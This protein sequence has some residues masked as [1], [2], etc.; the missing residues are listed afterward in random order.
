MKG[1]TT[2]SGYRGYIPGTGY[3]LFTTESEYR[4]YYREH[5]D[6]ETNQNYN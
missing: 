3:M 5:I 4:E 1:Y 2:E 6:T